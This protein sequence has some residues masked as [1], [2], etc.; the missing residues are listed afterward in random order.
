M[1]KLSENQTIRLKMFYT[2]CVNT[3][4]SVL[5]RGVLQAKLTA[6]LAGKRPSSFERS[7]PPLQLHDIA[8]RNGADHHALA[9]NDGNGAEVIAHKQLGGILYRSLSLKSYEVGCHHVLKAV[10]RARLNQLVDRP[11]EFAA[12]VHHIDVQDDVGAS[13]NQ[14]LSPLRP[15]RRRKAAWEQS[16]SVA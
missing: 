10:L 5:I 12:L 6:N 14:S 3:V 7:S 9:V 13:R 11:D 16:I 4:E 8:V 15:M 1:L 2:F